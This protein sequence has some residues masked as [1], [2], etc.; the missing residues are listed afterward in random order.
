MLPTSDQ[1]ELLALIEKFITSNEDVRHSY[2]LLL[3]NSMKMSDPYDLA[4]T[5]HIDP[6]L[7]EHTMRS[8]V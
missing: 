5:E 7:Q 3:R 2:W 8:S 4:E 6:A 1:T